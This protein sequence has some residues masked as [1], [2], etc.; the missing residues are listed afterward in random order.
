M[1]SQN[2]KLLHS[3]ETL[4]TSVRDGR[5]VR[6]GCA[7]CSAWGKYVPDGAVVGNCE[8]GTNFEECWAQGQDKRKLPYEFYPHLYPVR[9]SVGET[10]L[11]SEAISL[12]CCR[13]RCAT[14]L[15][16]MSA[17]GLVVDSTKRG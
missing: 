7:L 16:F 9:T 2:W 12:F 17:S 4:P 6:S 1:C 5:L 15:S 10:G 11:V 8:A 3:S 13:Q 14:S